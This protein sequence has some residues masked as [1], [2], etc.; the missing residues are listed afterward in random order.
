VAAILGI[1]PWKSP[2]EVYYDKTGEENVED[3]DNEYM[4][5]GNVLE[6]EIACEAARRLEVKVQRVNEP[7]IG[8]EPHH[9]ANIDRRIVD[10]GADLLHLSW[11]P[12]SIRDKQDA[13]R[14]GLECK[15]VN[16]F[17]RSD[18]EQDGIP[19]IYQAQCQWYLH[20]TGW[21]LWVMAALFGGNHLGLWN[22]LPDAAAQAA[23]VERVNAFWHDHVLDGVPPEPGPG[24][25]DAELVRKLYPVSD[26]GKEVLYEDHAKDVDHWRRV[27][28]QTS[29]EIKSLEGDK[30]EA[31]N[32]LKHIM[33]DGEVMFLPDGKKLTWKNNRPSR[34]LDVKALQKELPEVY[35]EYSE[36]VPGARVLRVP[37]PKKSK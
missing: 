15:A 18:W 8:A 1:S 17:A 36:E 20:V 23:I 2:L 37:K 21:D 6:H 7:I 4:L 24:D 35:D 33:G 19:L 29:G 31:A 32:H 11:V 3:R 26:P 22:V 25:P 27:Y 16:A 9:M 5:W 34:R 28:L 30:Q 10:P 14:M 13:V 12:E